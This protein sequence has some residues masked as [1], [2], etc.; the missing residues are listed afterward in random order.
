MMM[1]LTVCRFGETIKIRNS[2][3]LVE[4]LKNATV[5]NG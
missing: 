5:E 2:S 3:D 4:T 1:L